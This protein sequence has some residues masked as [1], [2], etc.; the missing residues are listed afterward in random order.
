MTIHA[1]IHQARMANAY[2][3]SVGD[4]FTGLLCRDEVTVEVSSLML[5]GRS[6]YGHYTAAEHRA[7]I[8][9]RRI[10]RVRQMH[11]PPALPAPITTK[12]PKT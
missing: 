12:E 3:V 11:P 5:T 8:R 1:A 4:R 9:A 10:N 6:F 2:F 7:R